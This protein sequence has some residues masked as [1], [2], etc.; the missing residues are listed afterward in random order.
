MYINHNSW[1]NLTFIWQQV[2]GAYGFHSPD[3][4]GKNSAD[5]NPVT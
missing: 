5:I 3:S 1:L 2:Q 4:Y